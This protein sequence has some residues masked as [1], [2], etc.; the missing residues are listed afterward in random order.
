MFPVGEEKKAI[1]STRSGSSS[2][3]A[4]CFLTLEMIPGC[5]RNGNLLML[6]RWLHIYGIHAFNTHSLVS[7]IIFRELAGYRR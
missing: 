6:H 1:S 4:G 3:A 2:E 5:S 7:S